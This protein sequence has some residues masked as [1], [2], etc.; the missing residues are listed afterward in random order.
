MKDLRKLM[1]LV[2]SELLRKAQKAARAGINET[3]RKGLDSLAASDTYNGLLK[4]RGKVKF[5]VSLS[6]LREDRR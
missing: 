5:S 6:E 2:H 1:V 4:K 3:V